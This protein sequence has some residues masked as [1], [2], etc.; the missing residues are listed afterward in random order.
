MALTGGEMNSF[1]FF[2]LHY[3]YRV[4]HP[5][6]SFHIYEEIEILMYFKDSFNLSIPFQFLRLNAARV[7]EKND[8]VDKHMAI[9]FP[10]PREY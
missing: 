10:L 7:I 2:T 4:L 6:K 8:A 9:Q 1:Q 5:D 3:E